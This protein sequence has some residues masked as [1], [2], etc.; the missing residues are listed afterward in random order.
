MTISGLP[1]T[2]G[3]QQAPLRFKIAHINL[4]NVSDRSE[5]IPLLNSTKADIL[6]IHEVTPAWNQWLQDSLGKDHPF[7]HT[8]VDIGIYGMAIYSKHKMT[9]IDTFYYKDAPN[10]RGKVEIDG[11]DLNFISIHTLPVL[12]EF[13]KRRLQEHLDM[14]EKE[15][16]TKTAPFLVF[17]DFNA[18]SW[19][20]QVQYFLD[21][22][23]L[24]ESRLGFM[25]SNFSGNSP[26]WETP[27]DHVF[28]SG[29]IVCTNFQNINDSQGHHL[30]ILGSYHYSE[31]SRHAEKTP[32]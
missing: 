14:V 13:S 10:L 2:K 26:F 5:I 12:D 22:T 32:K 4:S 7:S 17:G 29:H 8:L 24:M 25:P 6:S 19:S 30:G 23:G 1:P 18:V 31:R 28:Y 9:D 3:L 20:S 21:E 11:K 27:L 16:N 15:V